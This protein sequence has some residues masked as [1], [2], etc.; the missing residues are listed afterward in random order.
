M[1]KALK[2][3]TDDCVSELRLITGNS[4]WLD[5]LDAAVWLEPTSEPL[6]DSIV[7]TLRDGVKYLLELAGDYDDRG[8]GRK[9]DCIRNCAIDIETALGRYDV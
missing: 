7:W 9:A 2:K 3:T 4:T 8:M 1:W 6:R 5:T